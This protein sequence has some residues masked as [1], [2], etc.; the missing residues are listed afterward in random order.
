MCNPLRVTHKKRP[1]FKLN[2]MTL[3]SD[4]QKGIKRL[5][6]VL[7]TSLLL[8]YVNGFLATKVQAA[9]AVFNFNNI[10]T[11]QGLGSGLDQFNR[12]TNQYTHY[13]FDDRD[14]SSYFGDLPRPDPKVGK[15]AAS[16]M[17]W[18]L[19]VGGQIIG[20]LTVQSY[21]RNS[22]QTHQQNMIQTL[23]ATTAIAMDN[24]NAYREIEQNNHTLEQRVTERMADLEQSNQT[25]TALSEICTEISST[26]DL[27]KLMNTVYGHI[28]GL[29]NVD[30]F[31]IGL[32]NAKAQEIVFEMAIEKDQPLPGFS[33]AMAEKNSLAVWCID[34]QKPTNFVHVSVQNLEVDVTRFQQFLT[35]L[36]GDEADEEILDSFKQQFKPLYEHI[37]IIKNGTERIKIIVQ[38]LRAFT[39]LGVI[40]KKSV[41]ISETLQS[42]INLVQMQY[43]DAIAFETEFKIIPNL[44]CY[45]SQLNQ[46]FMNLFV[47]AGD[48]INDKQKQLAAVPSAPPDPG[49]IT[50]G[51]LLVEQATEIVIKDNG[52]G[53]SEETKSKLFEPFYATKPVGEG[54][55]LGLSISYGIVQKHEGELIVESEPGVGTIFTL[56]LPI[57]ENE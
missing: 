50:I 21:Q 48:A 15:R 20:V 3:N 19:I 1:D 35:D 36:V 46:V 42:T 25:I 12:R 47:N 52:I 53:M 22:Y 4:P 5:V 11:E 9:K 34:H 28:K 45:P 49:K 23:A 17:Y 51:C 41:S 56:M 18:P 31:M 29:M 32:Y 27:N 38:D 44:L 24:A 40:D 2:S 37:K 10:G 55:G 8:L 57:A 7:L 16:V 13:R 33:I 30:L 14:F 39:Q 6:R 26:L 54:T 43:V